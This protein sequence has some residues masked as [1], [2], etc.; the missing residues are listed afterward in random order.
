M[1]FM[2]FETQ[3]LDNCMVL[4]DIHGIKIVSRC[5]QSTK[6]HSSYEKWG[7][8]LVLLINWDEPSQIIFFIRLYVLMYFLKEVSA[9]KGSIYNRL[10]YF[11]LVST[12]LT[13]CLISQVE[14]ITLNGVYGIRLTLVF[15]VVIASHFID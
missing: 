9:V 15:T 2:V 3:N 7:S 13:L 10:H 8:R 1:T 5:A 12:S 6:S 14:S 11:V 4:N